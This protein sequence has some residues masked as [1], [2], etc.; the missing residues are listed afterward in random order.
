MPL[1]F[2]LLAHYPAHGAK[3]QASLQSS[4]KVSLVLQNR[5]VMSHPNMQ[6]LQEHEAGAASF[7]FSSLMWPWKRHT[8]VPH[9]MWC[10]IKKLCCVHLAQQSKSQSLTI[11]VMV[12]L[13]STSSNGYPSWGLNGNLPE[14]W[15]NTP[16]LGWLRIEGHSLQGP[17]PTWSNKSSI[18]SLSLAKKKKKKKPTTT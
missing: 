6:K 2:H 14:S 1:A 11:N 18:Q 7:T 9:F 17:L 13:G 10:I 5:L 15:G 8:E 16:N 3:W 12:G 4:F